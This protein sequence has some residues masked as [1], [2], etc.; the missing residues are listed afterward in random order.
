[1]TPLRCAVVGA[2]WAGLTTA[3]RAT[4]AGHRVHV[5]EMS[6][7]M[8]GRARTV[9]H[10]GRARDNGQHILVGAYRRTLNLMQTV[11]VD[12][13]KALARVPLSLVNGQGK[14]LR[15]PSGRPLPAFVRG[16][17]A[18]SQWTWREKAGLLTHAA[19]W[20]LHGFRCE[21]D[22][23]V[24]S[25][26]AHL[27][28]A[29]KRDLIE[30]LCVAALNTSSSQASAAVLLRVL[31]DALFSGAGSADL[32]LPRIGLG[33]LMPEAAQAWLLAQGVS[34]AVGHRVHALTR[35]DERWYVDGQIFDRI[36]LACS[37]AEAARLAR[38]VSEPW[39][40]AAAAFA[41]EPIITVWV[42][43]PLIN[44]PFPMLTL[45]GEPAQFAFD[46]GQLDPA[47]TGELSF[48]I[49]GA[50]AWVSAGTD[51][52][53][54]ALNAQIATQLQE[55]LPQGWHVVDMMTEKRATFR[56]VPGL[57][58]PPARVGQ[59]LFA[60]GDYVDGPYP[61]TLEGAVR[62]GEA[63]AAAIHS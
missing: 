61:A 52:V 33:Q 23:A 18:H 13:E 34:I 45:E 63:A 25:W 22:Q 54:A 44:A 60:A 3:V 6:P 16:V 29:V 56:C 32:L 31:R 38:P 35:L 20:A 30:P 19:N 8:G 57:Q 24:A 1:M 17:L 47:L 4:Q 9:L 50:S 7:T 41:Y 2:G 10:H 62:S 37:A 51:Q 42:R 27:P 5:F 11:G 12:P 40:E 28:S 48:V 53:M 43:A 26:C 14:G 46:L 39:A 59:D 36:V 15:L 55:V 49:S 21:P 58:R